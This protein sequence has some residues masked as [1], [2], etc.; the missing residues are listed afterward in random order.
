MKIT[1]LAL[2]EIAVCASAATYNNYIGDAFPYQVSA[3]AADTNGNTYITGNRAVISRVNGL[4]PLTDI[5][6]ARLD[7]A[8]NLTRLATFSGKDSDQAKGIAVDA[9]GNIYVVGSTGSPDFPLRTPLQVTPYSGNTGFL[10]KLTADGTLIYSTYLGGTTGSSGLNSVATDSQGNAYVTGWTEAPDY[11]HTDGLPVGTVYP[12]GGPGAIGGA[13]FAKISPAGDRILYAGALSTQEHDC[14]GGST[15]FLSSVYT[16]GNSIAV[17]PAG[18]AYIA[19]DAGGGG[20]P[21]TSG[22][23]QPNG[24]GAFVAKVN[25]AGN[26]LDYLTYLGTANYVPGGVGPGSNP[27][28]LVSAIAVDSEGNAYLSG[29]TADPDFPVTAGAFQ[30]ALASSGSYPD[31]IPLS[32]AFAAKLNP[33]G[34]AMVWATFLGGTGPDGATTLALDTGG[35]V[36]ISGTTQSANFPL[37]GGWPNGREFLVELNSTGSALN[38]S[39]LYPSNSVAAALALD[40]AGTVHAAGGAGLISAFP[41]GSAPTQMTTPWILGIANSAGGS[42]AGR[43]APGELFSIYGFRVGP[44]TPAMASFDSAGFLPDNLGGVTVTVNGTAAPLLYTSAT[45]INAIAPVE[46]TPAAATT[47]RVVQSGARSED[48]GILVDLAGP[49]IFRN[50]D[51]SAAAI[52]QDGT[53]NSAANPALDGSYVSVWLTGTGYYPGSD[54]QMATAAD[55]YCSLS[56]FCEMVDAGTGKQVPVSYIGAAPGMVHGVAQIN[57]QVSAATTSYSFIVNGFSSDPFG[58][59]TKR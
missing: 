48:F 56:D 57:F 58:I 11:P 19:G 27:V 49:Q 23:L 45:Q 26:G 2:F 40:P 4:P 31:V 47:L 43:L 25:A 21:T 55:Y 28:N 5:F 29:S 13:F 20:L 53:V 44:E 51:G 36:W 24:I 1:A 41:E 37:A 35:N 33:T 12:P 54:G 42:L 38:Y 8:R 50:A 14:G 9:S 17:D 15:C 30:T 52:N 59:F 39:A 16:S 10:L 6:V 32:N 34:S 46:L 22:V 7:T 18:N 3:A